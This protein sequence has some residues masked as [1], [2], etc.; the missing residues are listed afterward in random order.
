MK[1]RLSPNDSQLWMLALLAKPP[2]KEF[3]FVPGQTEVTVFCAPLVLRPNQAPSQGDEETVPRQV[4][5]PE[6]S[7]IA[8][9]HVLTRMTPA[10]RGGASGFDDIMSTIGRLNNPH[11]VAEALRRLEE[12]RLIQTGTFDSWKKH[13]H[14]L[15]LHPLRRPLLREPCS[16]EPLSRCK[17]KTVSVRQ[18]G[19][20]WLSSRS[21]NSTNDRHSP[22]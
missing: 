22:A 14:I 9:A 21:S 2:K 10:Q 17:P 11:Y 3:S 13:L 8:L 5:L 12:A 4:I 15:D 16:Q 20:G 6:A 7:H 18:L 19:N 1:C